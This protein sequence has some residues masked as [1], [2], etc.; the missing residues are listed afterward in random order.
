MNLLIHVI[1]NGEVDWGISSRSLWKS[2]CD[3]LRFPINLNETKLND[4]PGAVT[5]G[6]LPGCPSPASWQTCFCGFPGCL[7]SPGLTQDSSG[8]RRLVPHSNQCQKGVGERHWEVLG[9]GPGQRGLN[10]QE[11][12]KALGI[13]GAESTP[14]AA[15]TPSPAC[16]AL[17][18]HPP[19][20]LQHHGATFCPDALL[21]LQH[22]MLGTLVLLT[23][24]PPCPPASEKGHPP[25]TGPDTPL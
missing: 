22:S 15:P 5:P 10:Q 21:G 16:T 1:I 8:G 2:E 17:H 23:L 25:I 3:F 19:L 24:R 12:G 18:S 7:W 13:S 20:G 11:L 4:C 14:D 9:W 6:K